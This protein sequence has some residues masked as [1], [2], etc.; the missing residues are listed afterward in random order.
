MDS[1]AVVTEA[2]MPIAAIPG[3][4]SKVLKN[5]FLGRDMTSRL[6]N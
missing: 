6:N 5:Y 1:S 3:K 4:L 2:E